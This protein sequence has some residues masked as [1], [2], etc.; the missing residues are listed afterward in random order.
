MM[1]WSR[2]LASRSALDDH[3]VAMHDA[4]MVL[5]PSDDDDGLYP[6]DPWAVAVQASRV[7]D[8]WL[9]GQPTRQWPTLLSN[10]SAAHLAFLRGYVDRTPSPPPPDHPNGQ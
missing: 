8:T 6:R 9:H 7:F 4:G 1:D 3:L 10:W 2:F 5:A